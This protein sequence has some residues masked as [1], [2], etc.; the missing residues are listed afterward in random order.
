MPPAKDLIRHF[1]TLKRDSKICLQK[2]STQ[3]NDFK[4]DKTLL[5]I[6]KSLRNGMKFNDF[7]RDSVNK[8]KKKLKI[9]FHPDIK[10]PRTLKKIISD[11][12]H[13]ISKS[14]LPTR[15]TKFQ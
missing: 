12:N 1:K 5:N 6:T 11:P 8:L 3:S 14:L 2:L 13:P 15:E 10:L 7:K 9:K 4:C